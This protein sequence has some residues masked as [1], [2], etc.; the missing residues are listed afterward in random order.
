MNKFYTIKL[1]LNAMFYLNPQLEDA[2]KKKEE[3]KKKK[4]EIAALFKPV[5]QTIAKGLGIEGNEK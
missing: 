1:R 2:N 5:A 4:E 3:E